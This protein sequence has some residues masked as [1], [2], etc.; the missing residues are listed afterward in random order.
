MRLCRVVGGWF[1][2][3]WGDPVLAGRRCGGGVSPGRQRVIG[4]V[5]VGVENMS[6]YPTV[7]DVNVWPGDSWGIRVVVQDGVTGAA[8]DLSGWSWVALFG[9]AELTVDDDAA[10]SG[11]I[12]VTAAPA[13]TGAV[14]EGAVF[15]LTGTAP[16]GEVSTFV[17]GVVSFDAPAVVSERDALVRA[18]TIGRGPKGDDGPK[19]DKGDTGDV[20]P[21]VVALRADTFAARDAAVAAAASVARGEPNGTATLGADGKL[22][23][24]TARSQSPLRPPQQPSRSPR[25][26]RSIPRTRS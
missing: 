13:V 20:T 12:E 22:A 11:E 18:W 19:G 14:A 1:P 26:S 6:S 24:D 4:G 21:E 15:V 2:V 5:L 3:G 7:V 23:L 10:A 9:D 17:T 25:H 8:R 16:S